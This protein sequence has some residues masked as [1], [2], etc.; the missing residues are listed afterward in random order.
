MSQPAQPDETVYV[1]S[2]HKTGKHRYHTDTDC[3][4]CPDSVRQRDLATLPEMW[5]ECKYCA[6]EVGSGGSKK[7]DCMACGAENVYLRDHLAECPEL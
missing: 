3:K 4:R 1:T 5:R 2:N 7:T 6:D